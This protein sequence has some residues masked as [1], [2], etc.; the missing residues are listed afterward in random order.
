[1]ELARGLPCKGVPDIYVFEVVL[2]LYV[3][4]NVCQ[5][6]EALQLAG[7]VGRVVHWDDLVEL[8]VLLDG[9]QAARKPSQED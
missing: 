5:S 7:G 3:L 1:M 4:H 2:R 9:S 6:P 8:V